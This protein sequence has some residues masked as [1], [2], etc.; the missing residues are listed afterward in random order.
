MR[1]PGKVETPAEPRV[2]ISPP[3]D[4][5]SVHFSFSG[6]LGSHSGVSRSY[7]LNNDQSISLHP[8]HIAIHTSTTSTGTVCLVIA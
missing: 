1:P 8:G 7:D 2:I 5:V 3:L 4:T 6:Y